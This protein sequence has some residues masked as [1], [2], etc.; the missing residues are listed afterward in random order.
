M[1]RSPPQTQAAGGDSRGGR[2]R[3]ASSGGSRPPPSPPC[4]GGEAPT[5]PT[6]APLPAAEPTAPRCGAGPAGEAGREGGREDPGAPAS[7]GSRGGSHVAPSREPRQRRAGTAGRPTPAPAPLPPPRG[8]RGYR[9]PPGS[10]V[11]GRGCHPP[12]ANMELPQERR[13]LCGGLLS[14]P[15]R[16][17]PPPG[18]AARGGAGSSRVFF[19]S[20]LESC[21]AGTFLGSAQARRNSWR[22]KRPLR[23]RL[24]SAGWREPERGSLEAPRSEIPKEASSDL[25]SLGKE[26]GG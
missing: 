6:P 22:R 1:H 25:S 18:R 7:P 19:H 2:G 8:Y 17:R 16:E 4:P 3:A 23:E 11:R 10:R 5:P 13:A 15:L 14:A 20:Q 21:A 24:S 26:S 12:E 9:L